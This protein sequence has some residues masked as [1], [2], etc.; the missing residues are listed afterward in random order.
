MRERLFIIFRFHVTV[1]A[2]LYRLFFIHFFACLSDRFFDDLCGNA[3]FSKAENDFPVTP[4][5]I[6]GTTSCPLSGENAIIQIFEFRQS[7][8]NFFYYISCESF[9]S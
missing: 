7:V 3:L 4:Q 1:G 5:L 9:F 6:Y 2:S 8:N